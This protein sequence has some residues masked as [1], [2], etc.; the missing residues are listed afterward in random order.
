MNAILEN[1][2]RG[3]SVGSA[4]TSSCFQKRAIYY[5]ENHENQF[6]LAPSKGPDKSRYRDPLL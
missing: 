3:L 1:W 2:R 4:K 6:N 5:N